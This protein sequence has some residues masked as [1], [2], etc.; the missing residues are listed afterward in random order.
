MRQKKNEMQNIQN[1]KIIELLLS[2][3]GG[4]ILILQCIVAFIVAGIKKEIDSLWKR[5]D[6]TNDKL[7]QLIGEHKMRCKDDK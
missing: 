6:D 5:L 4:L 1:D 7:N 3:I 2:I